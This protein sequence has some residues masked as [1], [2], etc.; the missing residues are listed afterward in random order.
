MF[1]HSSQNSRLGHS[2]CCEGT[3]IYHDLGSYLPRWDGIWVEEKLV[4]SRNKVIYTNGK[5]WAREFMWREISLELA[6]RYLPSI[7]GR[8]VGFEQHRDCSSPPFRRRNVFIQSQDV[9]G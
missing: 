4:L 5:P 1:T 6:M 7:R 3:E 9:E 2:N 8:S